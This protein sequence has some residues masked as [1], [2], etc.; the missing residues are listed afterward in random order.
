M[1]YRELTLKLEALGCFYRRQGQGSHELWQ[2]RSNGRIASV[3]DTAI[4]ILEPERSTKSAGTWE[5]RGKTSTKLKQIG[6]HERIRGI[7]TPYNQEAPNP[8]TTVVG[9]LPREMDRR[10]KAA[11]IDA[12]LRKGSPATAAVWAWAK[13]KKLSQIGDPNYSQ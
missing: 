7:T 3:P 11:T 6:F 1:T 12:G 2:N 8:S 9:L 10:A 13:T 5:Y 4:A